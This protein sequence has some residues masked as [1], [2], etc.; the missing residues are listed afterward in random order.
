MAENRKMDRWVERFP[1]IGELAADDFAKLAN[2]VQFPALEAGQ[3]AYREEWECPNYIMCVDGR[4]RVYKTNSTGREV[5]I[6]KVEG[7]GTCVLTTQ[8][9][10]SNSNFPAESVAE[11][12]T[13]LATFS[14][15]HFHK[16]MAEIPAFRDFVMNDYTRLL[17]T[18]FSLIDTIAFAT[19]EQRLARRLLVESAETQVVGKTHQQLASDIG[20]VR[21]IVSRHLEDWERKGWIKSHRGQVQILDK[22]ALASRQ[23]N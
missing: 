18:M 15:S 6:Y 21:E 2:V 10:L 23:M 4:T 16:F 14:K 20:S 19:I 1:F 13:E 22:R 8:C 17:G 3:I 12:R 5:L 7:G 9:L 11:A